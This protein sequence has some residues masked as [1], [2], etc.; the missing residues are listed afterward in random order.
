[1][2]SNV[3]VQARAARGA[4]LCKPLLG[5]TLFNSAPHGRSAIGKKRTF[6]KR[7][8]SPHRGGGRVTNDSGVVRLARA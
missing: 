6:V 5:G 1:M 2:A 4:S 8:T 3:P 7:L